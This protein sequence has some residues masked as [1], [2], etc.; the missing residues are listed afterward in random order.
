MEEEQV[1]RKCKVLVQHVERRRNS[2]GSPFS[3]APL[4]PQS[5]AEDCLAKLREYV[6]SL[7]GTL[8]G[9]WKCRAQM[10]DTGSRAGSVD[11]WFRA[12]GGEVY[13]SKVA[14]SGKRRG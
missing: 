2:L 14:V 7:G 10:R 4:L 8:E 1:G 12:P 11:M 6:A 3:V 9:E 5:L 13:R